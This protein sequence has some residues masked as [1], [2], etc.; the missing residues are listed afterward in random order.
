LGLAI[1]R[2]PDALAAFY[3]KILGD[4]GFQ[5]YGDAYGSRGGVYFV[6]VVGILFTAVA[7]Y[8]IVVGTG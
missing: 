6:R 3:A 8:W 7:I 5:R 4:L 1:A 2:W